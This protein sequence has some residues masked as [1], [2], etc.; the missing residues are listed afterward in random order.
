[1]INLIGGSL[2]SLAGLALPGGALELVLSS[3]AVT[4]AT[5]G[6]VFGGV[7]V[8][9]PF[10]DTANLSGNCQVWS[11]T[12]LL[13]T[14]QYLVNFYD[15]DNTRI[16]QNEIVWQFTQSAGA[17]V[18]IGTMI[19][20]TTGLVASILT[21]GVIQVG[22]ALPSIFTVTNPSI[23]TFGALTATLAPEPA[24]SL[25]LGPAS[26]SPDVPAFR[27]LQISDLPI[28]GALTHPGMVPISQPDG[29]L[30][31][32]DPLIQGIQPEGS[33]ISTVNPVLIAGKSGSSLATL[34]IDSNGRLLVSPPTPSATPSFRSL[35]NIKTAIKTTACQLYGWYFFNPNAT[36]IYVQIFDAPAG[37]VNLGSTSPTMSFGIPP[38]GGAN[39][40]ET[41]GI[42]FLNA[43]TIACTTGPADSGLP[44]SNIVANLFTS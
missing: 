20:I 33:A 25:L 32:A 30:A 36:V 34:G 6:T 8:R 27:A 1:M 9:F 28:A 11:N 10:D 35:S 13:P 42:A 38:G 12:E 44:V 21:G 29:S 43:L 5:P 22:L 4:T 39:A 41:Q 14:T 7:P 31:F 24:H 26:G 3:D 18:D 17:T 40:F 37:N 2:Q 15:I 16:N 23:T 19:P